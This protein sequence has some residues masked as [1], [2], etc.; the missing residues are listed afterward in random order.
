MKEKKTTFKLLKWG[1]GILAGVLLAGA[2]QL[3]VSA[4]VSAD[5]WSGDRV[6]VAMFL[7]LGSTYK[8]TVPAVTLKPGSAMDLVL[9][10]SFSGNN[11]LLTLDSGQ[12]VRFSA[13]SNRIKAAVI[14]SYSI[15]YTKLYEFLK[16]KAIPKPDDVA[17]ALAIAIC[18]AHS[19]TLNSKLN[20]VLRS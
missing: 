15:H 10:T 9:Q 20:E 14:T 7:D 3:P 5:D 8:L 6:R 17:D 11:S 19:Y 13:G 1:R 18:H 4:P 12:T 16:L 2:L